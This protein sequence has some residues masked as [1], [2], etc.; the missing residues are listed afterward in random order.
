M[1]RC[2]QDLLSEAARAF[3]DRPCVEV[4]DE[5][6]TYR[7]VDRLAN[8]WAALL[9]D[10]GVRP[11]DRVALWLDKGVHVIAIMQ[12]A[13]RVGAVYVPIDPRNPA[14]RA[15]K[16]V[17]LSRPTIVVASR[18]RLAE[19]EPSML[20][21][22]TPLT[23][24]SGRPAADPPFAPA[25]SA[26]DDPAY[27]LFTSG[28]TGIPKG[29]CISHRN[30]LA[31]VN[32]AVATLGLGP[33]DRLANHAPLHFD[34]S[35]LDLYGAFQVGAS[36]HLIPEMMSYVPR[37]LVDFVV[38]KRITCLYIV[39]SI[40]VL[41]MDDGNLLETAPL[42]N[43]VFAG[44][45]FSIVHLRRL[46]AAWPTTRLFNFYG[47]TETNVCAAYEVEALDPRRSDPVPIG[48]PASGDEIWAVRDDGRIAQ[49]GDR[50]ELLVRGPTVM[51][52]YWG[53]DLRPDRVHPTG[54]IVEVLPSG[55]FQY[56]GRRDHM[57]KVRGQRVEL[58]EIE[59]CLLQHPSI[60]RCCVIV[61][62]SGTD[63]RL[64]AF[65]VPSTTRPS[66][67]EIRRHCS[68]R[69]PPAWG[70]DKVHTVA[71]LP[72]T[73]NGKVDRRLLLQLASQSPTR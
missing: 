26:P 36:V 64:H 7:D 37:S 30:A 35:V 67:L 29:V 44:E 60:R 73:A 52:G 61:A 19:F 31:F 45:P 57:V 58:A 6:A 56:I 2:L 5:C 10:R 16:I 49:V 23:P 70:I 53:E 15:S 34:L 3:P 22:A 21:G 50:G 71:E 40:L 72:W 55:E 65:V 43:L 59:T 46:R 8:W 4:N 18:E 20:F 41:M 12:A 14:L 27:I 63:A 66:L 11:G 39:P 25:D 9:L 24:P 48:G 32:W 13:L 38:S 33:E 28:S 62:G 1:A 51:L 54:D 69:L 17:E 42:P 47:P 68:E